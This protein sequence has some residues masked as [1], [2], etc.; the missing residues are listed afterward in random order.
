M[1]AKLL[2][3][4][5]L[6]LLL[7]AAPPEKVIL[8]LTKSPHAK[9]RNVPVSAVRINDGFWAARRKTNVEKSIPRMLQLLEEHGIVDNFRRLS[10]GKKA[11]RRGPLYTDSDLYK[12]MEAAAFVL[13]S[14][15]QPELK[16][17]FDRLTDEIVA[18][19][20]PTGYLNT[21]YQD[22]RKEPALQGDAPRAR[23]VLPGPF[24]TGGHRVLPRHGKANLLDGGIKFVD[25]LLQDFG[26]AKRPLL[27]GHPEIELALIELYRTTG[28][29]ATSTRGL[30]SARR[31]RAAEA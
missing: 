23:T 26:P 29:S 5:S 12:W 21:Y 6:G 15:D 14:D 25:Y 16:A 3:C 1:N 10:G 17:T 31:R 22:D 18:A 11:A 8:D 30:H 7:P 9:L 27:A 19:Q 2:L 13:Q 24:A 20:E 28:D 4:L